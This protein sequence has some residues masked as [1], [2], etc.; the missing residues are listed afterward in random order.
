V[1]SAQVGGGTGAFTCAISPD[2][3]T[4]LCWG[5]NDVG[6]LGNQS[7]SSATA[8]NAVPTVVYGQRPAPATP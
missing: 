6:Q 7:T 3:M 1:S 4:T 2:R 5:K 8:V